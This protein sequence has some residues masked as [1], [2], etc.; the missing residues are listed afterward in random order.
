M[1]LTA[2]RASS[3]GA[4]HTDGFGVRLQTF[5][6]GENFD[7]GSDLT[8]SGAGGFLHGD[9]F[10]EIHNAEAAAEARDASGRQRVIRPGG[11]VSERL[12]GVVADK[13]GAGAG[14]LV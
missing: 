9:H 4:P 12:R 6:S 10:Q 13:D 1:V 14:D 3:I 8:Q 11:I 5:G 2:G 7:D